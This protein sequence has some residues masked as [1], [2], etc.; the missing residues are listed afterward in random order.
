MVGVSEVRDAESALAY[1]RRSRFD[2]WGQPHSKEW[3][4]RGQAVGRWPLLPSAW[5]PD[6][7]P[8]FEKVYG[9]RS[10]FYD[11]MLPDWKQVG[12]AYH[13][14]DEGS[15]E[16]LKVARMHRYAEHRIVQAFSKVASKNFSHPLWRL[17]DYPFLSEVHFR[18]VDHDWPDFFPYEIFLVAQHH[19]VPTR[20]LDWS[21]DP[22]L[23]LAFTVFDEKHI[24]EDGAVYAI[25][26]DEL[27]KPGTSEQ[28]IL[29]RHVADGS[30]N[31]FS[32]RQRSRH[33]FVQRGELYFIENGEWPDHF[34][35]ARSHNV[36]TRLVTIKKTWKRKI[37][38]LLWAEG[39][40]PVRL[41]PNLDG[42]GSSTMFWASVFP[43]QWMFD[44]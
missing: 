19:G 38:K 2:V 6:K 27:P 33:T 39:V 32:F 14:F 41:V 42:V 31:D 11:R 24:D 5:R 22:L 23:A 44:G 29:Q 30:Q 35:F 16:N 1:F 12:S 21:A 28:P 9:Q 34:S 3:W 43:D 26:A 37:A 25:R 7:R 10:A 18:Q 36:E 40:D 8:I 4:F 20:F 17:A 13:G 15:A